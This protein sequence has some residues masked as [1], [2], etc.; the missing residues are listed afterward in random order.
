MRSWSAIS[1]LVGAQCDVAL[2]V[3]VVRVGRGEVAQRGLGLDVDEVLVVID[4]EQGLRRVDHLPDDDGGD[5]D[6]V[7]V[8]VVDLELGG[9]EVADADGD[10]AALGERVHPLQALLADRAAVP[11]EQDDGARLVGVHRREADEAHHHEDDRD[12]E[13]QQRQ[14]LRPADV[15]P[16]RDEDHA[17]PDDE[18]HEDSD[19]G[20]DQRQGDGDARQRAAG[21]LRVRGSGDDR[22]HLGYSGCSHV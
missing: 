6:G 9:L 18:A 20:Q 8:V 7:A 13:E 10:R 12:R 1:G 21:P 5:L 17:D 15:L 3:G 19:R 14:H 16:G 11:A 2:V 4:F 22:G